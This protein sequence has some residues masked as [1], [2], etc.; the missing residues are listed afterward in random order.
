VAGTFED[1][2]QLDEV[3]LPYRKRK[4]EQTVHIQAR[5]PESLIR[6]AD[7]I[8]AQRMHP[9]YKTR[10]DMIVD[11]LHMIIENCI[12]DLPECV[13]S[14]LAI[15]FQ[16]EYDSLRSQ[17]NGSTIQSAENRYEECR[18]NQ[19]NGGMKKLLGHMMALKVEFTDNEDVATVHSTHLDEIIEKAQKYLFKGE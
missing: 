11:G 17:Y 2:W 10:S 5:A 18:Q 16:L 14:P 8:V 12:R 6:M 1:G 7:E 4:N 19:D 13:N 3:R 9:G 15:G